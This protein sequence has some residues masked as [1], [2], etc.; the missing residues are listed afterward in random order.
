M[1]YSLGEEINLKV[2]G[3]ITGLGHY[4]VVS[5]GDGCAVLLGYGA[6]SSL[7]LGLRKR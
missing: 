1:P 7:V 3:E 4:A 2:S 5:A 6:L